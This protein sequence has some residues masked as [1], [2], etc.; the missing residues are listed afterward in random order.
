LLEKINREQ[1]THITI[2]DA[3]EWD[4]KVGD[5][6]FDALI[7]QAYR[8]ASFL[9]GLPAMD[10]AKEAV[11]RLAYDF[12]IVVVTS[13]KQLTVDATRFWVE[14]RFGPLPVIHT[15]G[16]KNGH[17]LD[18]LVD[19]AP[20]NVMAFAN[21]GRPAILFDQPWNQKLG[22]HP[23]IWRCENW[24]QVHRAIYAHALPVALY[25]KV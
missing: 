11:K 9:I 1:G 25:K 7:L 20:H 16:T 12:D 13:R 10:G 15:G 19:D 21:E 17:G 23:L 2:E 18:I 24:P 6:T 14:Q 8:D 22:L 3:I 5:T 4:F